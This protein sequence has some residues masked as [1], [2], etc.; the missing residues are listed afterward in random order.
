MKN[1]EDFQR[2]S[3]RRTQLYGTFLDVPYASYFLL[4]KKQLIKI[5][6]FVDSGEHHLLSLFT[7]CLVSSRNNVTQTQFILNTRALLE[8]SQKNTKMPETNRN[9]LYAHVTQQTADYVYGHWFVTPV[10]KV[11]AFA[12]LT[13]RLTTTV[14]ECPGDVK[15]LKLKIF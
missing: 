7:R 11:R 6:T 15:L 4:L 14:D 8:I 1:D 9:D 5:A 13:E 10:A 2:F 12:R 3:K